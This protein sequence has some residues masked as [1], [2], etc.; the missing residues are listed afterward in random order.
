MKTRIALLAVVFA[1]APVEAENFM[2]FLTDTDLPPQ[3]SSAVTT[4]TSRMREERE[5]FGG[6]KVTFQK[7]DFLPLVEIVSQE[8]P[9]N[10]FSKAKVISDVAILRFDRATIRVPFRQRYLDPKSG[11]LVA[12]RSQGLI[13]EVP[14]ADLAGAARAYAERMA[15]H[16]ADLD[17]KALSGLS[18]EVRA[19]RDAVE[20]QRQEQEQLNRQIQRQRQQ[21]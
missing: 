20:F 12:T 14:E 17:R 13:A 1:V 15:R 7:G 4:S 10:I 19:L 3:S 9:W 6:V 8:L 5:V 11:A 18:N 16:Q 21:R 2:V